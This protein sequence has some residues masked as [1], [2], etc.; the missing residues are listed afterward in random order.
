MYRE[1]SE[2]QI[3]VCECFTPE[4]TS[5][6]GEVVLWRKGEWAGAKKEVG[7]G[8]SRLE[9]FNRLNEEEGLMDH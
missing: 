5:S 9:E 4:T 3:S 2:I 1:K 6:Q 7:F 8:Q